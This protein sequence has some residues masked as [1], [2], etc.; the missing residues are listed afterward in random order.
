MHRSDRWDTSVFTEGLRSCRNSITNFS[1]MASSIRGLAGQTM[2]DSKSIY[3]TA[4]PTLANS[5]NPHDIVV[6]ADG[7]H[8][9]VPPR[10]T[11]IRDHDAVY[12]QYLRLTKQE[13]FGQVLVNFW[14]K[15]PLQC[16]TETTMAEGTSST[17]GPGMKPWGLRWRSSLSF[18]TLGAHLLPALSR[19]WRLNF[20]IPRTVVTLGAFLRLGALIHHKLT[21]YRKQEF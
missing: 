11:C 10:P 14:P 4:L 13:A 9:S 15:S 19:N 2:G 21:N 12:Y 17:G 18:V 5:V 6:R 16:I 7:H 8:E 3:S 20:G 1:W